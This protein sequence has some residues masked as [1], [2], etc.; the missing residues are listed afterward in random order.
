VAKMAK[1]MTERS[2]AK[3]AK[4]SLA[5]K[6]QIIIFDASRFLFRFAQPFL[7]KL[8][9]TTDSKFYPKLQK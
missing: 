9:L 4:R 3:Y 6:P 2:E 8:R 7:A 5:S 1:K